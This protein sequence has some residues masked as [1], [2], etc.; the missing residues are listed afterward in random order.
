MAGDNIPIYEPS[1]ITAGDTVT[2]R[3]YFSDYSAA[4]GWTLSYA[5]VNSAGQITFSATAD[6][7]SHL[8]EVSAATSAAWAAGEYDWQAYLTKATE[9]YAAGQGRVTIRAN[10]AAAAAGLDARGHA[11]KV[12]DALKS[13]MEGKASSDQLAMSIR[14]RSISRMSAAELIKW[15]DFYEK[16]VAREDQEERAR[17]GLNSRRRISYRIMN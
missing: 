12:L 17:R 7:D 5:L 4:E 16:Q 9:R 10:F 15:L 8:V 1:V 11:R 13:T 14:G 6:N 2:W 3:R